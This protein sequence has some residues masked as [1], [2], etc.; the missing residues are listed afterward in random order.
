MKI[1]KAFTA[2]TTKDR[3]SEKISVRFDREEAMTIRVSAAARNLTP[4]EFIRRATLNQKTE[5]KIDAFIIVA[6]IECVAAIR[7]IHA[8]FLENGH[9]P[10][11][12]LWQ[13]IIQSALDAMMR[14]DK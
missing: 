4:S 10:P 11:E 14:I 8:S 12:A 1:N 13:P 2:C 5:I 3:K 9:P 7:S 6:L